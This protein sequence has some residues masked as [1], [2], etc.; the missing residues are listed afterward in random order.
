[1][2][3]FTSEEATSNIHKKFGSN[4]P[5]SFRV[6]LVDRQT[7][8]RITILCTHP[9]GKVNITVQYT[10]I[11]YNTKKIKHN[12]NSTGALLMLVDRVFL[13]VRCV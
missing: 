9:G 5:S 7:D 11:F 4:R 10:S 12:R 2:S 6:M 3:G 8:I 1:M 13:P